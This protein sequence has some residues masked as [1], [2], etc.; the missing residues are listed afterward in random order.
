MPAFA[1]FLIRKID[2]CGSD[3]PEIKHANS[4]HLAHGESLHSP[5]IASEKSDEQSVNRAGCCFLDKRRE[6]WVEI[7]AKFHAPT[8]RISSLYRLSNR[9]PGNSE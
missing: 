6:F 8:A 2:M 7:D 5:S 3:K 1:D 9:L 4:D